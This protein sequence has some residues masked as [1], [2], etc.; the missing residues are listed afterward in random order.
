MKIIKCRL[1][2]GFEFYDNSHVMLTF[3]ADQVWLFDQIVE[4][5]QTQEITMA[6]IKHVGCLGL[7]ICLIVF[8]QLVACHIL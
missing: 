4:G 5:D 7:Y 2:E 6:S 8:H 3:V 1:E